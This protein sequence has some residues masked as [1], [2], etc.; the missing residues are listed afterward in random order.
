MGA[1]GQYWRGCPALLFPPLFALCVALCGSV[2]VCRSIGKAVAVCVSARL[3]VS[4]L[5]VISRR[6]CGVSVSV[7]VGLWRQV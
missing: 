7:A 3:S 6:G 4:F 5:F 2:A 1:L